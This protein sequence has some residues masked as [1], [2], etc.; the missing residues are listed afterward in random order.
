MRRKLK[1][2]AGRQQ[3]SSGVVHNP[4]KQSRAAAQ[5]TV[6]VWKRLL[7]VL[8]ADPVLGAVS[9]LCTASKHPL[10]SKLAW[11]GSGVPRF[12]ASA[13]FRSRQSRKCSRLVHS[14]GR[15]LPWASTWVSRPCFSRPAEVWAV[16]FFAAPPPAPGCVQH[17]RKPAW[18]HLLRRWH[19]HDCLPG[20]M[21]FQHLL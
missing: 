20:R 1:K 16:G 11:V 19:Q 17:H 4:P 18:Y 13:L 12:A 6:V 7:H 15:S 14:T 2:T 10:N 3:R 9:W 5:S 8:L 21:R